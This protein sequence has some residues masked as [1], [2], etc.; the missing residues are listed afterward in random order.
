MFGSPVHT[1]LVWRRR[2]GSSDLHQ[3]GVAYNIPVEMSHYG[4][5]KTADI[6]VARGL[7]KRMAGRGRDGERR[8]AGSDALGRS[9]G[10]VEVS[11]WPRKDA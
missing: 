7:A 3:F 4:V 2:D 6:A 11:G 5:S 8:A 10:D 9:R 1:S